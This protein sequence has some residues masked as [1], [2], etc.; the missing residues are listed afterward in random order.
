MN[1]FVKNTLLGL[2]LG[3]LTVGL[4]AMETLEEIREGVE[5]EVIAL[6]NAAQNVESEVKTKVKAAGTDL[7]NLENKFE[8]KV[9]QAKED[10]ENLLGSSSTRK[11]QVSQTPTSESNNNSGTSISQILNNSAGSSGEHKKRKH[12]HHRSLLCKSWDYAKAK[13]HDL[14]A[15]IQTN[16][17]KSLI[18][19]LEAVDLTQAGWKTYRDNSFWK[20]DATLKS[21]AALFANN[22][23]QVKLAYAIGNAASSLLARSK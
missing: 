18:I 2:L 5:K 9:D 12:H 6:Q 7:Q 15:W 22:M 17:R 11:E 10:I 19:A 13:G 16:P 1:L 8:N 3:A 4:H 21:R 14:H 20:K 23:Y